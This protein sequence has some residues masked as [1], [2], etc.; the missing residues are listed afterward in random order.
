MVVK[1]KG[2]LDGIAAMADSFHVWLGFDKWPWGTLMIIGGFLDATDISVRLAMT[3]L[4]LALPGISHAAHF[5]F[6]IAVACSTAALWGSTGLIQLLD[7]LFAASAGFGFLDLLVDIMPLNI[8][9]GFIVLWQKNGEMQ[10]ILPPTNKGGALMGFTIYLVTGVA[11]WWFGCVS[12]FSF[13][14]WIVLG[15]SFLVVYSVTQYASSP[16]TNPIIFCIMLTIVI[17]TGTRLGYLSIVSPESYR[18]ETWLMLEDTG[19]IRVKAAQQTD[20]ASDAVSKGISVAVE[21]AGKAKDATSE[22]AGSVGSVLA[23]KVGSILKDVESDVP[24]W[25]KFAKWAGEKLAPEEEKQS[26]QEKESAKE[27][28]PAERKKSPPEVVLEIGGKQ[29]G[30]R[31]ADLY[32]SAYILNKAESLL[33]D[34]TCWAENMLILSLGLLA[35][36]LVYLLSSGNGGSSMETPQPSQEDEDN[37]SL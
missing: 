29:L 12:T 26:A 17:V 31:E 11:L 27:E 19:D 2:V 9:A 28:K 35:L 25:N 34:R 7:L 10:N 14:W 4:F 16:A 6:N 13:G 24:A 22:V 8:F 37:L 15:L 1:N 5:I 36:S 21:V 3:P 20:T 32:K 18:E 33:K 23:D 30:P